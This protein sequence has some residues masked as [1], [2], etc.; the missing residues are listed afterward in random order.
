MIN[1]TI[2]LDCNYIINNNLTWEEAKKQFKIDS[3]NLE[4]V[5]IRYLLVYYGTKRVRSLLGL[6]QKS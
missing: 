1:N 2:K 5:Y 3:P 4:R 6:K